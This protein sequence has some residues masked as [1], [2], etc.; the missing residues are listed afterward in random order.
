MLNGHLYRVR[1]DYK[2]AKKHRVGIIGAYGR[3]QDKYDPDS[4]FTTTGYGAELRYS[5]SIKNL[6][7]GVNGIYY[8]ENFFA[9]FGGNK[10]LSLNARYPLDRGRSIR[11]RGSYN[12]SQPVRTIRGNVFETLKSRNDLYQLRYEWRNRGVTWTTTP[13]FRYDELLGL[14]VKTAGLSAA[15]SQNNGKKLRVFSRFFAGVSESPD[16]DVEPYP[17][18]RWE[19]RIR[20]KNLSLVGQYNYGPRSVTENLK[21][22]EDQINPQ[23]VFISAYASLYFRSRGFLFQPRINTRYES[24]FARWRTNM[25]A[26]FLYY[27]KSDYVFTAA[28]DLT[29]IKQGESPIALQNQQEGIEGVLEPFS[30]ANTFLRLGVK[31]DFKFKRPGRKSY[32]MKVVVFKDVD[33]NRRRDKGEEFVENI[34][35]KV[36]NKSAIT[37]VNGQCNFYNLSQGEYSIKSVILIDTQGWFMLGLNPINITRNETVYIPFTRGVQIMGSVIGQKATYSRS[38]KELDLSGIRISAI[39]DNDEVYSAVTDKEGKFKVF[40]PFGKYMIDVSSATIDEQFEFAQDSY[41]LNIDNAESNY[42]LTFFLIE[43]KRQLNI[44]KFGNNNQ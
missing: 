23:S 2:F 25:T 5:G 24:V 21:I 30:Q 34:I 11:F 16:Y 3:Q 17:V 41:P 1:A 20:F 4:V 9:R 33:G 6:N 13:S 15:F 35:I 10:Q 27:A 31:K 26:E 28:L 29:S 19:N 7:L 36:N 38:Y 44:K 8:S 39:S 14:R 40:V 42:E 43:K 37:N 22:L 18:A 12:S 32:E